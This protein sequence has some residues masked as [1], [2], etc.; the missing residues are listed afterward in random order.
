M[1]KSAQEIVRRMRG[2]DIGGS[3][4]DVVFAGLGNDVVLGGD[5]HDALFGEG[6]ALFGEAANDAVFEAR[7]V[8]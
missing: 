6:Y 3:G 8:G 1:K 5:G 2:R 4:D 7:R